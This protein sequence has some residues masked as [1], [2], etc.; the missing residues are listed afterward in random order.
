VDVRISQGSDLATVS[1]TGGCQ[2]TDCAWARADHFRVTIPSRCSL[3]TITFT[4]Q[5]ELFKWL[6]VSARYVNAQCTGDPEYPSCSVTPTT[7]RRL[8]ASSE[9]DTTGLLPSLAQDGQRTGRELLNVTALGVADPRVVTLDQRQRQETE[10]LRDTL[11]SAPYTSRGEDSPISDIDASVDS[12]CS[13][14]KVRCKVACASAILKGRVVV[15]SARKHHV[16][17]C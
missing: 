4:D 3:I 5:G 9:G 15:V 17:V 13:I 2:G 7:T 6:H 14:F 12:K 1:Y 16:L 8:A 10:S 11:L